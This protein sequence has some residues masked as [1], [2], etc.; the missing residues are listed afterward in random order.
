LKLIVCLDERKGMMFNNRRQ[1]RDRVLIDNMIKMVGDD[2]L[3][4]APYSESLFENKEIKLKVKKNPLK[5]A[6]E[7]WCFI[8]NLP[9]AE[10]KD[11]IE[12]VVIY[13]W[14]RHYPGDFFFDLELDSY[15]LESSEELVGSSHE[16]ITKEIWNK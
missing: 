7:N 1:S 12:T 14:N 6:D 8:E 4:I 5:A 3:Y 11:E 9:V 10:Y 13:H 2:K 16:K 15:T